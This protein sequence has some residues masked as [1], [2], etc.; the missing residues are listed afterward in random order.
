MGDSAHRMN[1]FHT[2]LQNLYLIDYEYYILIV[3][4][5]KA[6]VIFCLYFKYYN[7]I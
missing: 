7:L 5:L 2:F 4:K 3:P 6:S 1:N